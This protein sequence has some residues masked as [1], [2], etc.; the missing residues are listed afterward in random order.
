LDQFRL[1]RAKQRSRESWWFVNQ[2]K[3]Q[4]W[5]ASFDLLSVGIIVLA[6]ATAL[7]HFLVAL[8]IGPPT[9]KPFPLLFY[10][11][12]L[13]YVVLIV[14]LYAPPLQRIRRLIRWTLILYT[15][16][17]FVLWFMLTPH[18]DADG[19]LDKVLEGALILLLV[20]DD[21]RSASEREPLPPGN[22]RGC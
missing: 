3:Q 12:A 8:S 20:L 2:A 1:L 15:A 6:A 4:R 19:V 7:I 17:T 11:N 10:L 22:E 13:G 14:A 5:L 21:W 16:L 18:F 9:L